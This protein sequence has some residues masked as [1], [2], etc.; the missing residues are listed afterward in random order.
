MPRNSL[1]G[2]CLF[3]R[4]SCYLFA[5]ILVLYLFLSQIFANGRFGILWNHAREQLCWSRFVLEGLVV[6]F[7]VSHFGIVLVVFSFSNI[8]WRAGWHLLKSCHGTDL[9]VLVCLCG[10]LLLGCLFNTTT[11]YLWVIPVLHLFLSQISLGQTVL[12]TWQAQTKT[13]TCCLSY[14]CT[15]CCFWRTLHSWCSRLSWR[16]SLQYCTCYLTKF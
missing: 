15:Q 2:L 4:A 8:Y 13:Q 11:G 7:V 9:L 16:W 12:D 5:V 6:F 1:F 3:M 14:A 10:H